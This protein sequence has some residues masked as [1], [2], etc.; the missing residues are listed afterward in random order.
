[1]DTQTQTQLENSIARFRY[2]LECSIACVTA[3]A[4]ESPAIRDW[5]WSLDGGFCRLIQAHPPLEDS[6]TQKNQEAVIALLKTIG[7]RG[8]ADSDGSVKF[9]YRNFNVIIHRALVV[10]PINLNFSNPNQNQN[11]A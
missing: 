2:D 9:E 3:L 6:N 8:A 10:K 1:M 5:S 7:A 11:I 4:G